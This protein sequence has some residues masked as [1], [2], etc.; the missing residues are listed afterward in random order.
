MEPLDQS[1]RAEGKGAISQAELHFLI[2][3]KLL[4]SLGSP[5]GVLKVRVYPVG[6]DHF[7]VN[8]LVGKN[9]AVAKITSSYFVSADQQG[10][11]LESRPKIVLRR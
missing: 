8:V 7:R 4:R 1:N 5:D 6:D 2:G 9:L 11:I 10:N 3:K